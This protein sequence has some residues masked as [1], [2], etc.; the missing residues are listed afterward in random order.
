MKKNVYTGSY[1]GLP[2]F[3]KDP[4]FVPYVP[5]TRRVQDIMD[6]EGREHLKQLGGTAR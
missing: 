1:P 6:R 4:K 3:H 2:S 5:L